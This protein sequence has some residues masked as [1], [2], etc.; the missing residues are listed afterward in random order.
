MCD[1]HCACDDENGW[2]GH[3]SWVDN[4]WKGGCRRVSS[5]FLT[6]LTFWLIV[7][8]VLLSLIICIMIA[9]YQKKGKLLRSAMQ[10]ASAS[11]A[12]V[13]SP[14]SRSGSP[15]RARGDPEAYGTSYGTYTPETRTRQH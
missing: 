7:V 13:S 12:S 3:L 5:L 4:E 15:R 8:V 2:M 11:G 10:R 1:G 6:S 9:G 14:M